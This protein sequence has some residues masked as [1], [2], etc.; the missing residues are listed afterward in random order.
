[1]GIN[2]LLPLLKSIH[3][4]CNLKKFE[5]KT[6]GVDAYGWL[7]RGTVACAME[8]ALGKPT[9]KFV[10]FAMHRVRMLQ[11]FHVTPYIIFDGDYLPSKAATE[12]D[13]A[14]RR[15]ESKKAGM[16]LLN[17][18]KT[19]QAYLEFQK[20]VDV[21]PEMARQLIDELKKVGVQYIVAPY[22][23]DAQMVYLERKGIIDGILSEDSDLLVFGAKRLL[24]KLDQYGNCIEINKQDFCACKEISLTG[25]SDTQFRQMAILSG[26]DYLASISNMGLKTAYRMVR[27]HKTIEKV[28]R[29]LQFDGKFLVPKGYL[30]AFYQAELT[31][32]HQRVFC[33]IAKTLVLHTEPEQ[34]I[35]VDKMPFIGAHVA[36]EIA[37]GVARGDLNPMTKLPIVV[38]SSSS[39][40]MVT[41]TTPWVSS[42]PHQRADTSVDL[43]KGKPLETFF[44]PKR[45]PLA[46][47]DI[48]CFT[49]SPT[50]QEA[51]RRNS[52]AA[53][54]ASPAPRP[55]VHHSA[56]RH[57]QSPQ[58]PRSAPQ[59]V[60]NRA[61]RA[62]RAPTIS[63]PRP[64]KRPRLCADIDTVLS[65]TQKPV[66]GP[67][68]FFSSAA[69]EPSPTVG[70]NARS[71][72]SK[73]QEINIFSDDPIEEAML[74]LPDVDSMGGGGARPGRRIHVFDEQTRNHGDGASSDSQAQSSDEQVESQ[75]TTPSLTTSMSM[76]SSDEQLPT[77]KEA[78]P[79]PT[80]R[81]CL[82]GLKSKY[83]FNAAGTSTLKADSNLQTVPT[84][85][86][87]TKWSKIPLAVKI[88]GAVPNFSTK[89]GLTPLQR[90][91]DTATNRWKPTMTP[92]LTPA[93]T[94]NP[95]S[96]R[97]SMLSKDSVPF[98][99]V[100]RGHK[101]R[102]IEP[103]SIPLPVP[104]D[105]ENSA[106][107]R[108][109]GS[110]DMIVHDSEEDETL[111][112]IPEYDYEAPQIDL[113]RF[114]FVA[115]A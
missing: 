68:P 43:K 114:A 104:D 2:G 64:P 66:L 36:A 31:F 53:W 5:G 14:K 12:A 77:P 20:A 13:R 33:P 62:V 85:P 16:E 1:M 87:S 83:A 102:N 72:R 19:S 25:W 91:H 103:A 96:S 59:P 44:R 86:T 21:T 93:S 56:T 29:M 18:G 57:E 8:L 98:P 41:P 107:S 81:H 63:E 100:E 82:G 94:I 110:E 3:K 32:L 61:I 60:Q 26:C 23:A 10:D 40:K 71:K 54:S 4:P 45:I 51:L 112:P 27:K 111:S 90:L 42:R 58:L 88:N 48:N 115:K 75:D 50:Q 106:L 84:P 30:E 99:E 73:K 47:L 22:E 78:S 52:G 95:A 55:Y 37:Q 39:K 38:L 97:R 109:G 92:P 11:H 67:S 69:P 65:P 35:D 74:S 105:A 28:I 49:P 24:T 89:T 113:S 108:Q 79:V 6:I 76:T 46:E 9:R 7:H 70:R 34:P 101:T 80:T 15:E 17:A